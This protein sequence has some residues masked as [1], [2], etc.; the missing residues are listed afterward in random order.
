DDVLSLSELGQAFGPVKVQDLLG[1]HDLDEDGTISLAEFAE[2]FSFWAGTEHAVLKD[3][4]K[5]FHKFQLEDMHGDFNI[6]DL[7]KK[8]TDECLKRAQKLEASRQVT[9]AERT[10]L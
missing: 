1:F 5:K 2:V 4:P 3:T 6:E 8:I 7:P 9:G 10:E